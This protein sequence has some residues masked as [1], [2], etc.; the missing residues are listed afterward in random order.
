MFFIT[1][2]KDLSVGESKNVK[3]SDFYL[4]IVGCWT[5]VPIFPDPWYCLEWQDVIQLD[6][7]FFSLFLQLEV[8]VWLCSGALAYEIRKAVLWRSS[9]LGPTDLAPLPSCLESGA[10]PQSHSFWIR[11][12]PMTPFLDFWPQTYGLWSSMAFFSAKDLS[13]QWLFLCLLSVI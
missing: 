9:D 13:D 2:L 1:F 12:Q 7:Y 6:S 3:V 11:F 4:V 10:D 8:V 5:N